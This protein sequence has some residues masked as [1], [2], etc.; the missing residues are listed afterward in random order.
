MEKTIIRTQI[1]NTCMICGS[2]GIPTYSN[3]KDRNFG[4]TTDWNIAKC[5]NKECGLLWLNPMPTKEDI[6]KAYES[7]YTHSDQKKSLFDFSFFEKPYLSVRYGYYSSLA[8]WEKL[9]GFAIY[10]LPIVKNKF[11][12][13]VLYLSAVK[14]GKVLDFGCG[15]GWTLDNLK[16][17]GWD[18]YGLDFDSKAVEHCKSKGLKVN[19]GDIPSQNYPDNYFDAITINHVIEHVHEVDELLL[20]C[21]KKLK[22]GGK[23]V[24]AT[25]NVE[26]WQHKFYGQYWFQLDP[27]R[28]LHL[29]TIDNLE[30]IVKRNGF[31]VLKSF[32]SFRMDAW[33]TIVTRGIKKNGRFIIGKDK[34]SSV[35]LVIGIFHQNISYLLTRYN[36]KAAGEIV[37]V[38]TKV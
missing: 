8:L 38:A 36:K 20:N 23:L 24:I 21:F 28:H 4:D 5:L 34:K 3:L 27:P 19:L 33:S 6:G 16:K 7:Y 35:D 29:F 2:E 12:F 37:L 1:E 32:S 13:G 22:K 15:N 17:G 9:L 18:C 11:D 25:P 30:T 14:E 26:N 10:L 31:S